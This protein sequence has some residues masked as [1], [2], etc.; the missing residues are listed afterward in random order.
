[1]DRAGLVVVFFNLL[2]VGIR[3][4]GNPGNRAGAISWPKSLNLNLALGVRVKGSEE[5]TLVHLINRSQ[6]D[7]YCGFYVY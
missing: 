4:L 6:W 3:W 2:V 7:F 5:M 1:M